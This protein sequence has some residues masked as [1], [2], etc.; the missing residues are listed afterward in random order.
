[1][2]VITDKSLIEKDIEWIIKTF[3]DPLPDLIDELNNVGH[4]FFYSCM[5]DGNIISYLQPLK[6]IFFNFTS[7]ILD[8]IDEEETKLF[9]LLIQWYNDSSITIDEKF[10][11]KIAGEHYDFEEMFHSIEEELR[12]VNIWRLDSNYKEYKK[13]LKMFD[14]FK[15]ESERH[16]QAEVLLAEKFYKK[17]KK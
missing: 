10:I 13:L 5:E 12:D 6:E 9:P 3:H 14:M 16:I 2:S 8:H 11:E 4:S 7:T 17:T 15:I 1:M